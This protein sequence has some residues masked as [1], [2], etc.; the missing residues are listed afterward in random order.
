MDDLWL[1]IL[2]YWQDREFKHSLTFP[3]LIGALREPVGSTHGYE[4]TAQAELEELID[5]IRSHDAADYILHVYR[6]GDRDKLVI[7]RVRSTVPPPFVVPIPTVVA[8]KSPVLFSTAAA[9]TPDAP[10]SS[11]VESIW[12]EGGAAIEQG[13]FSCRGQL[14]QPFDEHELKVIRA[15][16]A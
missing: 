9:A 13:L 10:V 3:F 5:A 14:F 7:T 4:N 6:C 16:L 11:L 15:A 2:S 8:G 12:R 1:R